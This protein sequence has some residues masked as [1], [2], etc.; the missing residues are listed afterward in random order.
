MAVGA[1][2]VTLA[3]LAVLPSLAKRRPVV[4]IP[5]PVAGVG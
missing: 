5:T 4:P 2:A 3:G 1:A